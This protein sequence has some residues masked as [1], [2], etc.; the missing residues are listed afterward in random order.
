MEGRGNA[1]PCSAAAA[2]AAA[3]AG[4][5]P[6]NEHSLACLCLSEL[7][8]LPPAASVRAKNSVRLVTVYIETGQHET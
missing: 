2:A 3:A 6:S 1:V 4:K 5:E 8:A 7:H